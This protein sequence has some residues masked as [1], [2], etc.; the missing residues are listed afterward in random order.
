MVALVTF[1]SFLANACS[2]YRHQPEATRPQALMARAG[3]TGHHASPRGLR[4]A[5]GIGTLQSG[6]P[7]NLTQRWMGHARISTT[8]IYVDASGPEELALAARF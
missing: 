4:H 8:A 1:G 2:P 3:V 5:F 6:I 7:L